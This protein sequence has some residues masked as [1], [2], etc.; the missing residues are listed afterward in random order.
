MT[1]PTRRQLALGLVV[2]GGAVVPA[3]CLWRF[4]WGMTYRRDY[5][6][7]SQ[8]ALLFYGGLLGAVAGSVASY[9]LRKEAHAVLAP[10]QLAVT[11]LL[12]LHLGGW[13]YMSS[14]T[15]RAAGHAI[16][17]RAV[18]VGME[19]DLPPPPRER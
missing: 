9:L 18:L 2:I 7:A 1:M 14:V 3:L 10:F 19:R 6:E 8:F 11:T 5:W 4:G 17:R 16:A 12:L 15:V 13:V